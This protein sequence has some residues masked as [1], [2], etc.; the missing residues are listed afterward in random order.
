MTLGEK[1]VVMSDG[2]IRQTGKPEDIYSF[3]ADT[4]VATFIG[5]PE[6]NLYRGMI[7]RNGERSLF[8]GRGF[9]MDLGDLRLNLEEGE[10]DMGIRSEDVKT[11]EAGT[12]TLH[13]R[14]E[15]ISDVGSEKYIHTR[16]GQEHL[17][18]RAPKNASFRP[19]EIID[20]TIDVTRLHI[21]KNGVRVD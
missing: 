3:P 16:I 8:Q 17:T 4:F 19:D 10:V 18:L 7:L 12:K 6:M 1:V 21:F 5:S 9:S 15:M 14:V 13:A 20:L 11:G 2:E